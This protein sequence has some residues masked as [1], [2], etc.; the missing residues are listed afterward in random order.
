MRRFL[1]NLGVLLS[2]GV[3]VTG[4][5]LN[6]QA[7]RTKEL[8]LDEVAH[9]RITQGKRFLNNGNFRLAWDAFEAAIER[10]FHQ[11]TTLAIYLSGLAAY[12]GKQTN[13]AEQRFQQLVTDFPLS[14]YLEEARYHLALITL[15]EGLERNQQSAMEELLE[16]YTET[17]SRSLKMDVETL[18]QEYAFYEVSMPVLENLYEGVLFSQKPIFLVPL[19]HRL[20]EL[21]MVDDAESYYEDYLWM[22]GDTLPQLENLFHTEVVQEMASREIYKMALVLPLHHTTLDPYEIN[23]LKEIPP[24]SKV[25]LEFYEGFQGAVTAYEEEG[26]RKI[27]VKVLD[28]QRDSAVT[29]TLISELD[30]FRPDIL[31]GDI[32]NQ[33]SAQ[34]STWAET[35]SKTQ[36]VPLSPSAELVRFKQHT[37]LA[38]PSV[39]EHGVQMARFAYDSLKLNRVAIWTDR[40]AGTELLASAFFETFQQLGGEVLELE[41]DSVY[42]QETIREI[43]QLIREMARQRVQGVYLPI[44]SNQETC[45]LILSLIERIMGNRIKVMGSPHWWRRYEEIDQGMKERFGLYF[46][47]SYLIDRDNET[48]QDFRK[49]YLNKFHYPPSEYALQGYDLGRYLLAVLDAYRPESGLSLSDYLREHPVF[50]AGHTNFQ[51]DGKQS[52]QFVNIGQFQPSGIVKVNGGT[53]LDLGDLFPEDQN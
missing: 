7:Q 16:L 20:T 39:A 43:E 13:L 11:E 1:K 27:M 34:L 42:N 49:G 15:E 19:C 25:A 46:S 44:L 30:Q 50:R 33:Q 23:F 14:L 29:E 9:N 45:G 4:L 31:I 36:I 5:S 18:L 47:S 10:P 3:L 21:Q 28:S 48:Y 2:L 26:E 52:N 32:Y 41:V 6:V 38:H 24:N 53:D 40:R 17:A 8:L 35:L 37:F 12:K 22:G 51:F